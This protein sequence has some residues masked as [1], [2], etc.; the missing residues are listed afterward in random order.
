MKYNCTFHGLEE[1]STH[2]FEKLG[3]MTLAARD[4][5]E[6]SIRGYLSTLKHL[7]EKIKDKHRETVDVDRR[8][9]LEELMVNVKY[10]AGCAKKLCK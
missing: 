1:W 2:M 6:D 9:D 3:W 4:G 5:H 8:K 7:G 10:L